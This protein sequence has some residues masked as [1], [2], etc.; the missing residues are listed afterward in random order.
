MRALLSRISLKG[1]IIGGAILAAAVPAAVFA[2][3]SSR[4][5]RD[6][7]IQQALGRYELLARGLAANYE[8]FLASHRRSLES[9]AAHLRSLGS[10]EDPGL[11]A[12]LARAR[13]ADPAFSGILVTDPAGRVVAADPPVGADG[14]TAI[15]T[16][17][18]DR[19]WF[20]E[21]AALRVPTVDRTVILGR[22]RQNP[23]VAIAAPV[24]DDGG[25][26]R[27]IVGASVELQ[28]LQVLADE[29]RL[30]QTGRASVATADGVLVADADPALVRDRRSAA[31]LPVWP[32]IS[33]RDRGQ[34]PAYEGLGGDQRLAGFAT[35]P[36]AG[37]KVLVSQAR[38]EV[39][40][41]VRA[42]Y[43]GVL[44]WVV[45]ALAG[46]LAVV[47]LLAVAI[48]RPIDRLRA[49]ATAITAG[50]LT[51]AA[52]RQGPRE[53]V[54]LGAAFDEMVGRVAAGQAVLEERLRQTRALLAIAQAVGGTL[55]LQEAVRRVCRELAGLTGADTTAAYLV[56][57]SK[58][59][60]RPLA[61]YH[62]PKEHLGILA[63]APVPLDGQGFGEAVCGEGRIVWSEDV[64]HD[65]RFDFTLF[66]QFAH[67][68]GALIPLY[69]D[70][71]VSGVFYLVWWRE[72]RRFD[73]GELEM[74]QAV[75]RQVGLLLRA[76]RLHVETERRQR[77]ATQLYELTT[78]LSQSRDVDRILD[79]V[80]RQTLDLLGADAAGIF[81]HDQ[82]RG[83]LSFR[84]GLNLDAELTRDLVLQPGEG[85]AGRAFLGR[86]PAWTRDRLADDRLRYSAVAESLIEAKAPRAY[87]AVP[88]LSQGEVHGVLVAYFFSP[89]DFTPREIELLSTLAAH[90]A[91]GLDN[92]GLYER[93]ESRLARLQ[94][95]GRVNE[96]ISSSLD[97]DEVL[98][99]IARGA[100]R[101]MEAPLVS[102]WLADEDSR[103]LQRVAVSDVEVV[104]SHPHATLRYDQGGIGWVATHRELLSIPDVFVD[105]RILAPD[106]WRAQGFSSFLGVP[107]LHQGRLLAVLVL[108]GRRPFRIDLDTR[109]V[110]GSFTSQ[111]AVAIHN[112]RLYRESERRRQGLTAL[113]DV[114]QRLTRGLDLLVVLD[115]IA[116]AA[117]TLFEGEAGFRLVEGDFLV[118]AGVTPGARKAM[119]RERIRIGESLS[120]LVAASGQPI[121]ADDTAS[122]P[123]LLTE[124][125][126]SID[127]T[128]T[129]ALMCVPICAGTRVLGTLNVYRERGY[130]FEDESLRLA[131]SLADQASIA[132]ENARLYQEARRRRR[133]AETLAELGRLLSQSLDPEAVAQRVV[134]GIRASFGVRQSTLFR[135]EAETGDLVA[136]A[137]SGDA[138][139]GLRPGLVLAS[140]TGLAGLAIRERRSVATPDVLTDPRLSFTK[141]MWAL[142]E[143]NPCRGLL[144]A[145]IRVQDRLVGVLTLGEPAGRVFSA[146][147][148]QMIGAFADQ[149]GLALENAYLYAEA[150]RHEAE[151]SE[152]SAL[153]QATLDSVSQGISA[154]DADLR[155]V[156]WNARMLAL[157][158]FPPELGRMGT[159]LADFLRLKA[160]RGD[161]GPGDPDAIVAERLAVARR[162]ESYRFERT[163]PDGTV[164]EV[165]ASPMR[166]G[167]FVT[168]FSDI[169][170]RKRSEA[171]LQAAK[172][173]A[174]AASRAKGEFLANVSHEIRTP[175][176][177]II[178]MT[179]LALETDLTPD[180]REYLSL[181][182]ASA[183]S[184]L[185]VL[186]DVLDFSKIEAGKLDLEAIEF[187][188]RSS[189]GFT[190]K[191]LALRAHQK[192]LEL[193]VDVRPD[194]PDVV[195]GDPGRL[196]QVLVNLVGN[197]IKFT[198]RGE[199]V[200]RVEV[201]SET[202]D[203]VNLHFAVADTGI[204][205]PPDKQ[206]A[207][208]QAFTQADGSTTRK[209]GGTGLGL[210][211]VRQLVD[212][213]GGRVWVASAV[214]D[215]S[216]FHFTVRLRYPAGGSPVVPVRRP[217]QLAGRPAV[218]VDDNATNRRILVEMMTGWGMQPIAVPDA[219]D[220]LAVL[221][222]LVR[223]R[224][225]G[226]LPPLV[227]LDAQMPEVDGFTLAER[228][229]S[230]A[231]TA[232]ATIIILTSAGQ[233]GDAARCRA[234]GVAGYLTKP[235]AQSELRAAILA[236]LE[237]TDRAA[238]P[239]P[240]I[241]RHA[242]REHRRRLR[243]LLA[244]DNVVNQRLM[245]R[246]LERQGHVVR[247][248]A[249]GREVLDRLD[250]EPFDLVLMDIQMPEMDGLE[251]AAAIRV[252]E[253]AA[254]EAD[255]ES[256]AEAPHRGQ[257]RRRIP[258]VA[259]TARTMQGDA[260]RCLAAGIDAYLAKPMKVE[261]LQVILGRFF[262]ELE[263]PSLPVTGPAVDLDVALRTVEDDRNLLG[264]LAV[265][266]VADCRHRLDAV[267]QGVAVGDAARVEQM[268]HAIRGAAIS[269]GAVGAARVAAELEDM[270]RQ[271][272]LERAG[273]RV[274]TL[275]AEVERVRAFFAE[276]GR[277]TPV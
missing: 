15:G 126:A 120:G 176:N 146:D 251:A 33:A 17:F 219:A 189:V 110:L 273:D 211:I 52:V 238:N 212:L 275:D 264:Q 107:V 156:A 111:A 258:I 23:I 253:A 167:G 39:D 225:A 183:D 249:T 82:T 93:L 10:L 18:S 69:L 130:R 158:K 222:R 24:I 196:R 163:D 224:V 221:E 8:E 216:T 152:K 255:G 81:T 128:R 34:V 174:E 68:S 85:V 90:A 175:M 159:P 49:A 147:E 223:D 104:Q 79:E 3:A 198:D 57:A 193:A 231:A 260:D 140:G 108:N 114:S 270:A 141:E 41:E 36:V 125:R 185:G 164:L 257:R 127:A 95:F 32:L 84:R 274:S 134:E 203:G 88:I 154:F 162:F 45:L 271:G 218:I 202:G 184:L 217:P 209:Y 92:A 106:W 27:G 4:G 145:P 124:H 199:V 262:P 77:E 58:T 138:G 25:T 161:Y 254:E 259:L 9:V 31:G 171:A 268:A 105:D 19:V 119:A 187:S 192:G 14:R 244:E 214:G 248:A 197:A 181:V 194:V 112:A 101:L 132:I 7:V 44:G 233:P 12:V 168:T 118:R 21:T 172:E 13:L 123:R 64:Q 133:A 5:V 94:A 165:Q 78:V 246:L 240:L 166:G 75:G 26:L 96:L 122:D 80:T 61:A 22:L 277:K 63:A 261:A 150:K 62:V 109:D 70:D 60:L 30:G 149:A 228:I 71:A 267:R 38:S 2:V 73:E 179:D 234:L 237:P 215:G 256:P 230:G 190:L 97:V 200:V 178:G 188:L 87:L 191:P 263:G 272:R 98:S 143:R 102:F 247:A 169:S 53:I 131:K 20:R 116:A 51:R 182:R 83:G 243:V 135:L 229:K 103:T 139:P 153:L 121:V 76:A 115:S 241:T 269:L 37:W 226:S 173:A 148:T 56:D 55:D 113:L 195:V 250:E 220:T 16:D 35:V 46:T 266:F 89:H 239:P 29:I 11:A 157:L 213:M 59:E 28:A 151:L 204:G 117:A 180:Q 207:I 177:G 66:R 276:A 227:L 100:A 201:E 86:Q 50:D 160:V 205:I 65:A 43:H 48:A 42:A 155:L 265:A 242:L 170:E 6:L 40:E 206:E 1:A 245:V 91:I 136:L 252:R 144:A 67:Q 54:A 208:F 186:N 236:T 99:G 47:V 129:G 232:E 74:L 235:F 142:V 137:I 210:A 72:R